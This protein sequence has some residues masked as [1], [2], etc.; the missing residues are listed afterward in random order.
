MTVKAHFLKP[1]LCLAVK[2]L[3]E[4]PDWE[5]ELKL[6]G[7]RAIGV[8]TENGARIFS[9]NGKKFTE[10]VPTLARA[11]EALPDESLID[12]EIVALDD[13]GRPS[14]N[15]LQNFEGARVLLYAFDLLVIGGDDLTRLRLE[16]RRKLLRAKVMPRLADPIRF[17][18]TFE[19][20]AMEMIAAVR[21]HGLEGVVAKRR[22]ICP[23]LGQR[24]G[25]WVKLRVNRS[26]DLESGGYVPSPGI[27]DSI[28]VGN[29]EGRDLL[30]A[31][32]VRNGF[33]ADSRARL[34]REFGGLE[35]ERCPFRNLPEPKKRRWGEGLAP[36]GPEVVERR[37][38]RNAAG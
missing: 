32:R 13:D 31:A 4:G 33:V 5:Y 10:R 1:M 7:Y 36:A 8:K 25:D 12:G 35:I 2:E 9:R 16:E 19:S 37:I 17:S 38:W 3:P 23:Q 21:E 24:S 28:L 20:T 30:S 14:F 34:F 6:D 18:E 29:Y 15:S 26:Q 27:F 22:S 11:L